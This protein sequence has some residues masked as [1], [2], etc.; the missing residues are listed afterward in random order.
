VQVELP[1]AA[2]EV[3]VVEI[4]A[5]KALSMN[6][7]LN[8]EVVDLIVLLW[9]YSN[10]YESKR[11]QLSSMRNV[12]KMCETL[13]TPGKGIDLS[14]DELTQIVLGSL[15][16]LKNKGLV[17]VTSAGIHYVKGT[18]TEK[19]QQLVDKSISTSNLRR[20]TAEFGDNP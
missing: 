2:C 11:R 10:P 17:Y 14:E 18:L 4:V 1:K 9:L 12:L 8:L 5:K 15:Q 16:R 6:P 13:Q 19:G 7:E 3:P 20:V